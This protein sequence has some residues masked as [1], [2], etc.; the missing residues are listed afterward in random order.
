MGEGREGEW[1]F[2]FLFLLLFL[3]VGWEGVTDG[4]VLMILMQIVSLVIH[5][6]FGEAFRT[7]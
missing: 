7:V 1:D 6:V 2:L 5:C 4:S 3:V